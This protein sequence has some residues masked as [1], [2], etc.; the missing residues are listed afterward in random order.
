M[1]IVIDMKDPKVGLDPSNVR[2]APTAV[3]PETTAR[4]SQNEAAPQ[5]PKNTFANAN[6]T[7]TIAQRVESIAISALSVAGIQLQDNRHEQEVALRASKFGDKPLSPFEKSL[8]AR[9]EEG[10][11]QAKSSQDG[12]AH[13]LKKSA[14]EWSGFFEK[15]LTRAMQKVVGWSDVNGF[16]FRGLLQEKG[17]PQKGVMISDVLTTMG[18]DKFARISV[19]MNKAMQLAAANPGLMVS[20]ETMQDMLGDQLS[21]LAVNPQIGE[22]GAMR[23]AQAASRGMFTNRQ[24][25][26]RVAE[27]LGLLNEFRVDLRGAQGSD[28]QRA[29]ESRR[30]RQGTWSRLFGGDDVEGNGSVFV[31]WWRWDREERG[32]MRRWFVAVFGS[33]IFVLLIFLIVFLL[34]A[35]RP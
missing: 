13:F 8:V 21:Y 15:F 12:Q 14:G 26:N 30:R 16:L 10:K 25:E 23:F 3:K 29:G 27:H 5:L 11:Q 22:D 1:G 20:K 9:F 6:P 35:L 7:A 33:V 19:P 4:P 18:T 24:L 32:G 2:V 17:M 34:R 31:P 28:A